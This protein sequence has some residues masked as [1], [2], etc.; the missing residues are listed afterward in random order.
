MRNIWTIAR[1]EYDLYFI[2]PI[3]YIIL[4]TMMLVLGIIFGVNVLGASQ[5]GVFG[6]YVPDT[7]MIT[8][9]MVFMFLLSAPA[10]TMRLLADEQRM[11]TMEL[12]L[13]APVRDV[14]LVL[15]KWLG[16]FM[17]ILTLIVMT[18]VFPLMLNQFTV[19]GIDWKFMLSG[20]LGVLLVVSAFLGI[21][22]GISSMFSNQIAAFFTTLIVLVLLW[23]L[24]G[25][26]ANLLGKGGEL[27]D[28]LSMQTHYY[29]S[30]AQGKIFLEDIIYYLSLTSLGIFIGTISIELRRWR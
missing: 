6:G 12:L 23:W 22:V 26:P 19:P 11:G 4:F 8:N 21:G 14:E 9:S 28:Y 20:Y 5:A 30:M 13:T 3:A 15:G 2:S 18:L 1:R 27:F 16:A 25:A 24:I 10:I 7:T 17:F 29:D